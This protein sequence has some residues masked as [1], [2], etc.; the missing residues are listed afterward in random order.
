M[1]T[2]AA[3]GNSHQGDSFIAS[4]AVL[5]SIAF[6]VIIPVAVKKSNTANFFVFSYIS[7]IVQNVRGKV[8]CPPV[9]HSQ[10]EDICIKIGAGIEA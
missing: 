10:K 9:F 4:L 3:N 7:R 5:V 1:S 2:L 6:A 8:M